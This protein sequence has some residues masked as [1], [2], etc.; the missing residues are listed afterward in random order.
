MWR[1][2]AGVE[3]ELLLKADSESKEMGCHEQM[4]TAASII[5]LAQAICLGGLC[6]YM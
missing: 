6:F 5:H 1:R 3:M 4:A 2:E